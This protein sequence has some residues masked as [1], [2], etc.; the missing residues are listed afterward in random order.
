MFLDLVQVGL[1]VLLI[2]MIFGLSA[3]FDDFTQALNIT[4]E[5]IRKEQ[6]RD[7]GQ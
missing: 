1:L 5:E 6:E 7:D 3:K 2:V 4:A